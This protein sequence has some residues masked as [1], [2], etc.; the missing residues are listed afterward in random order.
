MY[1]GS[2][3]YGLPLLLYDDLCGIEKH[4]WYPRNMEDRDYK[5]CRYPRCVHKFYEK[6]CLSFIFI[7]DYFKDRHR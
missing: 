2:K 3:V 1:F 4:A 6:T 5:H 7:D